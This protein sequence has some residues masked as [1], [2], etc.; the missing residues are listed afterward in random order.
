MNDLEKVIKQM[1]QYIREDDIGSECRVNSHTVTAWANTL[2][3]AIRKQPPAPTY[4]PFANAE[5]FKPHRD[6]WIARKTKGGAFKAVDY[7]DRGLY[8]QESEADVL[9]YRELF[10]MGYTFEDGTPCGVEHKW[11][12]H[13]EDGDR[14]HS[15]TT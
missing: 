14:N 9:T 13:Y 1:R 7:S 5:E 3:Q 11:F 8:L 15:R 4:R 2:E 12:P 10:E 6:K